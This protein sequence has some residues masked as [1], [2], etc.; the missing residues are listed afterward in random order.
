MKTW[1]LV[2][3]GALTNILSR[4]LDD[5]NV[6]T[7]NAVWVLDSDKDELVGFSAIVEVSAAAQPVLVKF[8]E[9]FWKHFVWNP[10]SIDRSKATKM[11]RANLAKS[12][13][14]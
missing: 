13:G 2:T 7:R 6:I 1:P 5:A 10:R 4:P 11:E 8:G 9:A 14:A 12:L 3:K